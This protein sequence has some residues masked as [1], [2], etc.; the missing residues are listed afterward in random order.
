VQVIG[1]GNVS[2]L[3]A[4]ICAACEGRRFPYPPMVVAFRKR[5]GV[6]ASE[7]GTNLSACANSTITLFTFAD[8]NVTM[9]HGASDFKSSRI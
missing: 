5:L 6:V 9:N 4:V 3:L 1:I 8:G 2:C 7:K